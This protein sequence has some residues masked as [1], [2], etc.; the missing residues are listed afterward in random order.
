MKIKLTEEQIN[1]MLKDQ[2]IEICPESDDVAGPRIYAE[3][4]TELG[5]EYFE[6][7][8]KSRKK[9][10]ALS[11]EDLD[12]L[13][14]K[15]PIKFFNSKDPHCPSCYTSMIYKFECC[16]RCGQAIDWKGET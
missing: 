10:Y 16:P 1:E 14:P 6:F 9:A 7:Y 11:S 2:W 12:L 5:L 4:G 15:K 13:I 8:D 3:V